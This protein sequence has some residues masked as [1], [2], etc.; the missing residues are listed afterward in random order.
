MKINSLFER[1]L[2]KKDFSEGIQDLRSCFEFFHPLFFSH[3]LMDLDLLKCGGP[4]K[5]NESSKARKRAKN[6]MKEWK[7]SVK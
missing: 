1:N 6:N 3:F 5:R 4:L 7:I 2:G